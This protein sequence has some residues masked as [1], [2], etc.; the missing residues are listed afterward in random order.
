M[1]SESRRSAASVQHLDTPPK[2]TWD[3]GEFLA[4]KYLLTEQEFV[5]A[6]DA[7][8]WEHYVYGLCLDNGAVFYVGKGI[9]RRATDHAKIA[10]QGDL[11]EKSQYIRHIG[12]RLRYTLFLQ[13]SDDVFAKGYE[14]YLIR[15]HH[16]VLC[17]LAIPSVQVFERMFEPIDP[18]QKALDDLARVEA[19]V[20]QADK[21]CRRY[22]LSI[23]ASC[24]AILDSIPDEDLAWATG[25]ENGAVA[26]LE[27]VSR[28]DEVEYG[29][30]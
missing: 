19:Y 22:L 1:A 8:Q 16:D 30:H 6:V 5:S 25:L 2:R 28:L 12:P 4:A 18:L 27:I 9:G 17:N 10:M 29:G 15:G 14:A 13:C 20:K 21:E 26:R 3:Q 23:I 24:P 11:S 7:S